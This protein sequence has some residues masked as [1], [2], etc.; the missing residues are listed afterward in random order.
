M[1]CI[2]HIGTE[3]T[4]S[5]S[6]QSWLY[7]N[8]ERLS[9]QGIALS[10]HIGKPN[11]RM[12]CSLFQN[13]F[14]DFYY[15][16]EIKTHKDKEIFFSGFLDKFSD[17]ISDLATNHDYMIITSE[18]FHSRLKTV[19]EIASL[20]AFL[21][22]C[23]SE[24][25]VVCYFREQSSV[26]KSL[27]STMVKGGFC[28][29]LDDFQ[30]DIDDSWLYYNYYSMFS[31]WE[32][33]FGKESLVPLI[34]HK[35]YWHGADI[36]KDFIKKTINTIDV[37]SLIYN[38][39]HRNV[40]LSQLQNLFFRAINTVGYD[41]FDEHE[42]T[43]IKKLKKEIYHNKELCIGDLIDMRQ[44]DIWQRFNESN[45]KFFECY[46]GVSQNLFSPPEIHPMDL[47]SDSLL[48]ANQNEIMSGI[49]TM[50]KVLKK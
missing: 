45:I 5:T 18:H 39:L 23:F 49:I 25:T 15:V 12:L 48:Y 9:E 22:E 8:K 1:K 44:F 35:N 30:Q 7:L 32:E 33:E 2:L 50:L 13:E 38:E 29:S 40:Q 10:Q 17:E 31:Q 21:L 37:E 3:K 19:E 24:V 47:N 46:F 28:G 42:F 36:R 34:F 14:D 11:N 26:R 41:L 6:I 4:A 16:N 20:R 27:Y 43:L